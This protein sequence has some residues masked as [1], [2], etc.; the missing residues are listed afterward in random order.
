MQNLTPEVFIPPHNT[1]APESIAWFPP[2][3]LL[4]LIVLLLIGLMIYLWLAIKLYRQ[5]IKQRNHARRELEQLLAREG[6][7]QMANQILKRLAIAYYGEHIKSYTGE[8][9]SEFLSRTLGRRQASFAPVAE[10]LTTSIYR[11][12][13]HYTQ[14]A[15][16]A[17]LH[18]VDYGI[19]RFNWLLCRPSKREVHH[20]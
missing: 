14:A 9:W 20:A 11:E 7:L 12:E 2:S 8:Q 4:S 16:K 18:W 13:I 15:H 1:L 6:L 3:W 10:L 17:C 19:P 5:H